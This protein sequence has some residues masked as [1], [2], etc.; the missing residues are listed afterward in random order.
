MQP[1]RRPLLTGKIV[2]GWSETMVPPI[3]ASRRRLS[4]QALR[5]G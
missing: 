3:S 4:R 5:D 1:V 2:G